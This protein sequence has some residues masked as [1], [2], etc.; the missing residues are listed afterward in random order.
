MPVGARSKRGSTSVADARRYSNCSM[1][2]G[3]APA[4]EDA[5]PGRVAAEATVQ[6]Q[7]RRG[8]KHTRRLIIENG[9]TYNVRADPQERIAHGGTIRC[10]WS[11]RQSG[12]RESRC[13]SKRAGARALMV[14]LYGPAETCWPKRVLPTELPFGHRTSSGRVTAS[15]RKMATGCTSTPPIW[16]AHR[17]AGGG[18]CP[19]ARRRRRAPAMRWRIARSS[20]RCCPTRFAI[21]RRATCARVLRQFAAAVARGRRC[22]GRIRTIK[23]LAVLLTP[24]PFNE[25]YFE[26]AYLA[27]QLGLPLAEGSDLTV[28]G[29]TVYLKTLGGLRR[30]HAILRRLDDDFLRSRGAAQ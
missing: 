17:M 18:C 27:G 16:R 26:H 3:R 10:R 13:R 9:V 1:R 22:L 4:Q 30:V 19:I 6:A 11:P 8:M 2:R 7:S 20:S 29:E 14:D 21:S 12:V 25:T 23:P 15:R 28:R 24:G 5:H